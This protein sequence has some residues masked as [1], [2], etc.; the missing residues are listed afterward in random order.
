MGIV[1]LSIM[2]HVAM[3]TPM[4]TDLVRTRVTIDLERNTFDFRS[5]K[6]LHK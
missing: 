2:N 3:P 5:I 6:S 4:G 1:A